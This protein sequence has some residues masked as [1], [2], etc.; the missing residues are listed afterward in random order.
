M[1]PFK[2]FLRKL[3]VWIFVCYSY[4]ASGYKVITVEA[5]NSIS[6]NPAQLKYSMNVTFDIDIKVQLH[7]EPT[8]R[9]DLVISTNE[10][11]ETTVT[12]S[13]QQEVTFTFKFSQNSKADLVQATK[14]GTKKTHKYGTVGNFT[15]E[16]TANVKWGSVLLLSL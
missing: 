11:F 12:T 9:G 3:Y 10:D 6:A 13:I 14:G 5:K 1:A 16:I 8:V 2:W 4:T 15:V 7:P